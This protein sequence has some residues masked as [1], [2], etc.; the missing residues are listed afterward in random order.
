MIT[1]SPI[2]AKNTER[3]LKAVIPEE[4]KIVNDKSSN[5]YKFINLLY[6]AEI[7]QGLSVLKDVYN[8]S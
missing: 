5:G 4:F 3:I 2:Q 6:G 7:D 8:N 1:R